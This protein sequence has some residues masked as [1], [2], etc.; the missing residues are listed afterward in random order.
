M[1]PGCYHLLL[2]N[3]LWNISVSKKGEKFLFQHFICLSVFCFYQICISEWC[4]LYFCCILL[5]FVCF[6]FVSPGRI[7]SSEGLHARLFHGHKAL[8]QGIVFTTVSSFCLHLLKFWIYDFIFWKMDVGWLFCLAVGQKHGKSFC[9]WG[10]SQ[11][12]DPAEDWR[13]PNPESAG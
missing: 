9:I 10:L 1:W 8:P 4:L 2:C 7:I 12:Q 11:G 5:F 3:Q 6:R 13:V